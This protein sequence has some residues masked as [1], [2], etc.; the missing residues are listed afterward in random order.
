MRRAFLAVILMLALGSIA[1]AQPSMGL[2]VGWDGKFRPGNWTPVYVTMTADAPREVVMEVEAPY[3][4]RYQIV[5]RQGLTIGP[6]PI[7]APIYVP[8]NQS[9]SET[10][11]ALRS[12]S[13]RQLASQ[14][15]EDDPF[16]APIGR[17]TGIVQVNPGVIF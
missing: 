4:R 7:T 15:L 6:N 17:A 3:D 1:N 10:R 16:N 9:L 14:A 8:L 11:I 5:I 13:G 2:E 12:P